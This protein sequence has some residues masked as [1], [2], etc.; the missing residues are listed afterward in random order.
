MLLPLAHEAQVSTQDTEE[1]MPLHY[2]CEMINADVAKLLLGNGADVNIGTPGDLPL[3]RLQILQ[4]TENF[5]KSKIANAQRE[6]RLI[7]LMVEKAKSGR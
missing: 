2:T 5:K 1:L 3:D 4:R 6:I 7:I